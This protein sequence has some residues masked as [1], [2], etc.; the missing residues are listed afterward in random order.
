MRI[1]NPISDNAII[2]GSFTGS[3][4]GDGS[5]LTG[6]EHPSIPA[7]VVSGSGQIVLSDTVGY[8]ALDGRVTSVEGDV[9]AILAASSAD[10]DSFAEIVTLINSVDTD[11]DQAFAGYV[12]SN[13]A[14]VLANTTKLAG[15]EEGATGDQTAEEILTALKTV[16]GAGSG[17]DADLLDGQSSSYYATAAAVAANT[18]ALA[19]LDLTYASDAD[20]STVQSNIDSEASTRAAADTLLQANIDAEAAT[21][22]VADSALQANIDAEESARIAADT[23]L[24]ANIDA[25]EVAR[26]AADG[27]L[28]GKITTEKGRI[29]AILSASS[30]DKDSFAE[31]VSLINTVDTANDQAFA[32]YVVSNNAAVANNATDISAE[33]IARI[34]DVA[35]INSKLDG[36]ESGATADQT[37]AEILAAIKTVDGAGSGLDADLLD[38][39]SSAYYATATAVA[40]NTSKLSGIEA[41]A[42]GDQT[43][44][45]IKALYEAEADTNAF[46]DAASAKLAG[47]EAGATGD[48]TAAEILTALK[49][50]DGTG[51]GLDADLL[52]G[53]SSAYYATA[54]SVSSNTTAI[55]ANTSKLSGIEAGATGDQTAAEILT[56]LKTVDGAGSGLDA[57]LLDGQSSAYYATAAAVSSNTTAIATNASGIAANA[58]AIATINAKDPVLTVT[59]DASGTATFTNLGNASMTLTIADDSHNHTIANVDGLQSAL[60]AKATPA[61]VTTAVNNLING[62]GTAYDTLKELGDAITA[63]DSD[64]STILTTQAGLQSQIN[65]KQAAGTYNTIIGTDTDVNTSG[66]TIIDNIYMTDGVITSHGTRVLTLGDLGYTG[67]TNA[68]YITNNNQLANGAGYI[69]SYTDT[70]TT[71][72]AGAGLSLVGTVFSHTDTSAQGS[73][74]NSGRTYIQ[75]ITLDGFGHVTGIASATETVVNTDTNT[76]YS[77]GN[78]LSLSGTTFLMSGTYSGNFTATGDITAYSDSRLKK[79]VKTI[80][81]ALDKTKAL[82]G[83]EFTRISDDAKSIGVIAQELEAVLPELV[84]TD[85]EGMKSVNYAQITGLLIEAV[86]ELSAKVDELSK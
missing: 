77:A 61:D 53:Q 69:T 80:E 18:Q 58:S 48:Q 81:G 47:I 49:T 62:A 35:A 84:L 14:A 23:L 32:G 16:D 4:K 44:A 57:D 85:D 34:S 45:E 22:A 55:A 7:G 56:A 59:G 19:D 21:R 66:A 76:T 39:Q 42:T 37:P 29:D 86:K 31:I 72:S 82:R 9:S 2:T 71:Y 27:V 60:D 10:K 30:A 52:D 51:S 1:D 41:G 70:N 13:D 25:E 75:D 26:I 28:D 38:G 6:I 11:N 63:N 36:I 12:T 8:S 50:V 24:Q 5:Q 15:I 68:N 33:E 78:G 54:A 73:V 40:A 65:G 43:G 64:I 20:V 74:N 46:T 83:V 67:A 79:D 3:F 17:L